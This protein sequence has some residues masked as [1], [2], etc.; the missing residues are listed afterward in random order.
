M[1]EGALGGAGGLGLHLTD[2]PHHQVLCPQGISHS[3][4]DAN[5]FVLEEMYLHWHLGQIPLEKHI[6]GKWVAPQACM[7]L[8]VDLP[9]KQ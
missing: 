2:H 5:T 7:A 3:R 1:G 6:M 9:S 8:L 4:S